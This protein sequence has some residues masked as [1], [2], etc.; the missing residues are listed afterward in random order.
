MNKDED[1]GFVRGVGYCIQLIEKEFGFG[2]FIFEQ[3]GMTLKDFEKAGVEEFDLKV[4]REINDAKR[5]SGEGD[6]K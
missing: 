5:D 1:N 6:G 2:N 3:S 4:I